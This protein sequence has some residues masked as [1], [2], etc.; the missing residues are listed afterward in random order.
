M[1][2]YYVTIAVLICIIFCFKDSHCQSRKDVT[3]IV[4]AGKTGWL[5]LFFD[6]NSHNVD[7]LFFYSK[8]ALNIPSLVYGDEYKL[9]FMEEVNEFGKLV[10][11]DSSR[12]KLL[13]KSSTSFKEG[14]IDYIG[15]YLVGKRECKDREFWDDLTTINYQYEERNLIIDGLKYRKELFL[16]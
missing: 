14:K 10:K 6:K 2:Q 13:Q 4:P 16:H 11:V 12:I 1:R 7:S 8:R 9:T 15:F 5:F 3:I